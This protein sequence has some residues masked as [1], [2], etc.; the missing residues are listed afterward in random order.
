MLDAPSCQSWALNV[1]VD[2]T[3]EEDAEDRTID[4]EG[5]ERSAGAAA[6]GTAGNLRTADERAVGGAL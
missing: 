5:W 3:F 4:G 6:A 1:L 2:D